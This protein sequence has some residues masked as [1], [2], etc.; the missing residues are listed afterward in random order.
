[1][2]V[3][4]G[5]ESRSRQE[6]RVLAGQRIHRGSS[7]RPT[8]RNRPSSTSAP[9]I[10]NPE[11]RSPPCPPPPTN[12]SHSFLFVF[13]KKLEPSQVCNVHRAGCIK[14]NSHLATYFDNEQSSS[15]GEVCMSVKMSQN[16]E[17]VSKNRILIRMNAG[18]GQISFKRILEYSCSA[19]GSRPVGADAKSIPRTEL[20]LGAQLPAAESPESGIPGPAHS[21]N[22][23]IFWICN[24]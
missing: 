21:G 23:G 14:S 9:F 17:S 22:K 24:G 8:V 13:L 5:R 15:F 3:R 12:L 4:R 1:M 18:D 10:S 20:S 19:K 7:R 11:C 6:E 2:L 16:A